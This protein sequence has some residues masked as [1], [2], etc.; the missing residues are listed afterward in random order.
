MVLIVGS[1]RH[2]PD[3][4]GFAHCFYQGYVE[5]CCMFVAYS[6]PDSY[7]RIESRSDYLSP[8]SVYKD[9]Y[10][11]PRSAHF[12]KAHH[13]Q[14]RSQGLVEDVSHAP[15][16][17]K[18]KPASAVRT[19]KLLDQL[20]VRPNLPR[21]LVKITPG[22]KAP[23]KAESGKIGDNLSCLGDR[24]NSNTSPSQGHK[25]THHRRKDQP[26]PPTIQE[27][28][29]RRS[30]EQN[31]EN[32][33]PSLPERAPGKVNGDWA[34]EQLKLANP[35]RRVLRSQRKLTRP[36]YLKDYEC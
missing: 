25:I 20:T 1:Y 35:T 18:E 21:A 19:L 17:M 31:E 6:P 16:I 22:P 29:S 30:P 5:L 33:A 10:L 8:H 27:E 34:S 24:S 32:L 7:L 28:P 26:S 36:I 23:A 11:C 14:L 2:F 4:V 12:V 15:V 9:G 3:F 13:N